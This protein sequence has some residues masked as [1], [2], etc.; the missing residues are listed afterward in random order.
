MSL[1]TD[2]STL[3]RIN[4]EIG[5]LRSREA[6]E[7]KKEADA[8]RRMNAAMASASKASNLS[9]ANSH[10]STA[11]R[12]QRAIES[13]QQ[14]RVRYSSDVARK[15]QEV[16]RL[17]ERIAREEKT[18]RRA[19]VSAEEKRR[20]ADEKVR[21]DLVAANTKLREEYEARVANLEA[22]IAAQIEAR[23]SGTAPFDVVSAEGQ[24]EPYDFFLSH[25][26]ADKAEFADAFV[27]KARVRGLRVWYDQFSL[28]WGDSI[29][30]KID[31]GLRSAYF[32]VVLLSPNFFERPWPNYELD[33][34]VQKDLSGNGRLLP[35]WHRLTQDDV[36]AWAPSIAGRLALS[37]ASSSTETILDELVRVRDRFR[38]AKEGSGDGEAVTAPGVEEIGAP[39]P[40]DGGTI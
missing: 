24:A 25:A 2:R 20:K 12:E 11:A 9:T 7:L 16:S 37:T 23:A 33:G 14:Q 26:W 21:K 31:E 34:I 28:Q 5:D 18:Q 13:A 17:Q 3:A 38:A 8:T 36:E 15:S 4:R 35:I 30:Q 40:E 27:E 22:Q 19:A 32:G 39:A 1:S 29:R 6:D 10:M